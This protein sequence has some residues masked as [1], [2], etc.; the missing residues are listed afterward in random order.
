MAA[1][2]VRVTLPLAAS[3]ASEKTVLALLTAPAL[4]AV[5]PTITPSIR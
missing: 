2:W 3:T 5:E 1:Y 4:A